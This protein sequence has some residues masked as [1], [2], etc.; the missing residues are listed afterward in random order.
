MPPIYIVHI[1]AGTLGLLSGY[2]ALYSVKGLSLHRK[3]GMVFVYTMLTMAIAGT[4]IAATRNVAPQVNIPAGLLTSYLVITSLMTVRPLPWWSRFLPTPLMLL[5][6]IVGC[7]NLVFGIRTLAGS[8]MRWAGIPLLLFATVGILGALG[9][10]K[11]L[12]SAPLRGAPRI[13]RHLWRMSFALFIAALSFFIGQAKVIPQPIRIMPVLV[14]PVLAVLVTMLYWLWR[15]R[16][17]RS[18]QGLTI[19]GGGVLTKL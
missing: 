4:T 18:L 14:L 12:R 2:L 17:R 15:I 7:T 13:V 19:T 8:Q 10:F 6:F 5:A 9:D 3:S 1:V 11:L 16:F